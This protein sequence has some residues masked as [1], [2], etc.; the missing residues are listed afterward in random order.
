MEVSGLDD[1]R[2]AGVAWADLS[3]IQPETLSRL[4][5]FQL[6]PLGEL[7]G[8]LDASTEGIEGRLRVEVPG[9]LE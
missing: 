8:E 7:V 1:A 4:I 3:T 9:G 2:G 6:K 5:L